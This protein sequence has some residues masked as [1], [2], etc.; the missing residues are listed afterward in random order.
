ML[1]RRTQLNPKEIKSFFL[2]LAFQVVV[3]IILA[4]FLPLFISSKLRFSIT[5]LITLYVIL[6][7]DYFG[8]PFL[9]FILQYIHSLFSIEGWE[10]GCFIGIFLWILITYIKDMIH[11]KSILSIILVN[12]VS[13]GLWLVLS[14]V[15]IG[16]K[17]GGFDDFFTYLRLNLIEIVVISLLSPILF[18]AFEKIWP[19]TKEVG[20]RL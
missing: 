4:S 20:V 19:S 5:T 18:T 8:V 11:L 10:I 6:N 7:K 16:L 15:A 14:S 1:I 3:E 9:I 2:I 12:F 17:V 13:C